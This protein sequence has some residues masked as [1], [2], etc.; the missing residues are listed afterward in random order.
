MNAWDLTLIVAVSLMGTAVAYLRQPGHKAFVLMLPLPFTLATLAV[1]APVD[2]SNVA[3]W[4]LLFVFSFGVWF[5][6]GR[7]KLPILLAIVVAALGYCGLSMVLLQMLPSDDFTF[8]ATTVVVL[9]VAIFLIRYLP[10]RA[11][12]DYRT[13][14]PVWLKLPI[15]ALVIVGI[16]SIKPWLG[17]FLTAFPMVGVVAAYESRYSLWTIM[18][19][20]P[21]AIAC[22]IPMLVAVRLTQETLGLPLALALGWAPLLLML[23]GFRGRYSDAARPPNM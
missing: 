8:W 4:G 23:W 3:A 15:I 1:G 7:C 10:S 6:N 20:I 2:A 12:A 19:R 17:G 22:M 16:L 11:E 9:L 5:L 21:W 18:R 14:L 13:P